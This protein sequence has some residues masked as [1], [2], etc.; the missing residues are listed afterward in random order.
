MVVSITP[1]A[2]GY[3]CTVYYI[4]HTIYSPPPPHYR[5]HMAGWEIRE[6]ARQEN[7]IIRKAI[8]VICDRDRGG[9]GLKEREL[10]ENCRKRECNLSEINSSFSIFDRSTKRNNLSTQ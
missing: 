7:R 3:Y 8:K 10:R 1:I 2:G 6:T 4:V 9:G 5:N